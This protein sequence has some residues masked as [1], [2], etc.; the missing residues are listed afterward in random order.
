MRWFFCGKGIGNICLKAVVRGETVVSVDTGRDIQCN[1]FCGAAVGCLHSKSCRSRQLAVESGSKNT[2][3]NQT[4][5]LTEHGKS[6][7]VR[8]VPDTDLRVFLQPRQV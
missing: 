4:A 7:L 1:P 3:E 8:L 2:V 5:S 6:L